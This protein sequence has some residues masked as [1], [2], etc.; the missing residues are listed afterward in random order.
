MARTSDGFALAETDFALRREGD[1]LGLAQSGLPGL[2]VATLA[3]QD[4]REL[5]AAARAHAGDLLDE[6]GAFRAA[7]A[8]LARELTA[9][10]LARVFAGDPAPGS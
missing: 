2:R 10:W 6:E 5:A 8:P 1:V 9:G 3:R 4:H 7:G